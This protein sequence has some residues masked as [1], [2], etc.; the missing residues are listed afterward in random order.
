MLDH[1]RLLFEDLIVT[2]PQIDYLTCH[3]NFC[4]FNN[5]T[6]SQTYIIQHIFD[7]TALMLQFFWKEKILISIIVKSAGKLSF[8]MGT[9]TLS[10]CN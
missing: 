9:D 3:L 8:I 5:Q 6:F 2:T 7:T 10:I 4:L 1:I